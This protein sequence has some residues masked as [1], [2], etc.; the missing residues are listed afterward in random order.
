M[1]WFVGGLAVL[2]HGAHANVPL[3]LLSEDQY[4]AKGAVCLDG[5]PPG[6]YYKSAD[7]SK[8]S[9]A[10]ATTSWLLYFKGGGWCYNEKDCA[11]R[12]AGQLGNSSHFPKTFSFSGIADETGALSPVL[13]GYN[14]VILWYCDGASFSGDREEPIVYN[15]KN[16]FFRGRRVLD[17]I[18]DV[19][20]DASG[21]YGL[22][23]ATQVLLSGGSAGGLSTILHADHVQARMPSTVVK[24]KAA[25]VSGFFLFHRSADSKTL[26]MN[27]MKYV[28]QMQNSSSGVNSACL[29][30]GH[31]WRCIFANYSYSYSRT[32]MYLL[33]S[34]L[35]S[36]QMS[37][38]LKPPGSCA[39]NNFADCDALQ[40]E[41]L[42]SY[43]EAMV[44]DLQRT[45]KYNTAGEGGFVE[46]CL[47]HVAAQGSNFAKYEIDDVTMGDAFD[48]W[49][50]ADRSDPMWH[51][52]CMLNSST[53]HQCNPSCV[54]T[55]T[56]VVI[57]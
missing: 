57:V 36:W 5:G 13:A 34:S 25:P 2:V 51:V 17:A 20:L 12:A 52:P 14:H 18:L 46:T 38:I 10:Q 15:G 47:E 26:Y 43:T 16:I 1:D 40:V 11:A 56:S 27:E 35:D 33:Q 31:D 42:N 55:L 44:M 6:F 50:T 9:D 37:N 41:L 22:G 8:S 32:P 48:Q 54:S 3:T 19:L 4:V 53:P 45:D 29:A 49:W 39:R 23:R 24:F 28:F 30:A 7:P 21:P